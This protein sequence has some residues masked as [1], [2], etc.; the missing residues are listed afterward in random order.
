VNDVQ[1]VAVFVAQTRRAS[2][3]PLRAGI[4]DF[5]AHATTGR[6]VDANAD[7]GRVRIPHVPTGVGDELGQDQQ[8]G[9]DGGPTD[10]PLREEVFG[11][12]T[13]DT[14]PDLRG[15]SFVAQRLRAGR[16]VLW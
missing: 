5:D 10:P 8:R 15:E 3:R 2:H 7:P 1:P 6:G 13:R 9:T 12:V 14:T 11:G 16:V 4:A